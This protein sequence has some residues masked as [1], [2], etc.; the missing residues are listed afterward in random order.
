LAY[1]RGFVGA[2][3]QRLHGGGSVKMAAS[4]IDF[5]NKDND[6][7][8]ASNKRFSPAAE[9]NTAVILEVL[10]GV[11]SSNGRV[12]AIAEGSGQHVTAFAKHFESVQFLPTDVGVDCQASIA[13]YISELQ[14]CN[15]LAPLACDTTEPNY[16]ALG[17]KPFDLVYAINLTHISQ[18]A[19]TLGLLDIAAQVLKTK[20]TL[21]V[22]GPFKVD[23][24]FTTESN[25]A[26]DQSLR[27]QNAEWGYRDIG[28]IEQAAKARGLTLTKALDVP[29][30]NHVLLFEK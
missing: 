2:A 5:Q 27:S 1:P 14:V 13:E 7:G 20:G 10:K 25:R 16:A 15:V 17:D 18:W 30:N 11:L 4:I 12:L 19:A 26:F 21:L 28:D 3:L 8:R 9:R 23:G 24:Q 22:Y 6:N 29:A